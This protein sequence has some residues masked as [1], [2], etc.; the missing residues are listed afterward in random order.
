MS[1]A[2]GIL[3]ESA[4]TVAACTTVAAPGGSSAGNSLRIGSRGSAGG[5]KTF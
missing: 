2:G 1:E 4:A 3:A 5:R